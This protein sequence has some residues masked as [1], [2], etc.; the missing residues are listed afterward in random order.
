MCDLIVSRKMV[1]CARNVWLAP[2]LKSYCCR[3]TLEGTHTGGSSRSFPLRVKKKQRGGRLYIIDNTVRE[4][5]L[6][7]WSTR[8]STQIYAQILPLKKCD[9]LDPTGILLF[10]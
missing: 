9:Y 2:R 10:Q 4:R 1:K 3:S 8:T 5:W 6:L 7:W